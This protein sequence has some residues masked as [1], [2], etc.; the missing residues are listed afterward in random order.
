M[1]SASLLNTKAFIKATIRRLDE[2]LQAAGSK[3]ALCDPANLQ[4]IMK[5]DNPVSCLSCLIEGYLFGAKISPVI[6]DSFSFLVISNFWKMRYIMLDF[7]L[8]FSL[9]FEI[10]PCLFLVNIVRTLS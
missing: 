8:D 5:I 2:T 4:H 10:V 7:Y 6:H 3:C 9:E 1:G